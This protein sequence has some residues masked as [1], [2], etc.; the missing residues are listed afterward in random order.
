M[1][2]KASRHS[3]GSASCRGLLRKKTVYQYALPLSQHRA[4]FLDCR[5]CVYA[6]RMGKSGTLIQSPYLGRILTSK[7]AWVAALGES[8]A[9]QEQN[10]TCAD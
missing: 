4:F 3:W 6:G 9:V 8:A 2:S 5:E 10:L 7:V 1:G